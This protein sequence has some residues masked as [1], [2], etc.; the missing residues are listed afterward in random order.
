MMTKCTLAMILVTVLVVMGCGQP[1]AP[2]ADAPAAGKHW[3]I[4]L[5]SFD[6]DA[7]YAPA[8]MQALRELLKEKGYQEGRDYEFKVQSAQGEMAVVPTMIDAAVAGRT[9]LLITFQSPV[10]YAAMQR[11]PQVN[12][13][14]AIVANP[15]ALGTGTSDTEHAPK[16]TG[17]YAL[18]PLNA[19]LDGLKACRPSARRVGTLAITGDAESEM[20]VSYYAEICRQHGM[21][22]VTKGYATPSEANDA[23]KALCASQ[24]DAVVPLADAR[25]SAT[26]AVLS[27]AAEAAQVP[28]LSFW[29]SRAQPLKASLFLR[30]EGRSAVRDTARRFAEMAVRVLEGGDPATMPF[31]NTADIP[32]TL[33]GD[34][35][36]ARRIGLTLPASIK[37][38]PVAGAQ[39]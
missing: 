27:N 12:K 30:S 20:L 13:V 35:E 21:E 22:L 39:P 29:Q 11:A 25:V 18:L 5:V 9:D 1:T 2:T 36:V 14:F 26:G 7:V 10:L 37:T 17:C 28:L 34:A 16:V 32:R 33:V 15:F 8:H 23:A 6:D 4:N 24:V 3:K 19:L 38:A 31:V